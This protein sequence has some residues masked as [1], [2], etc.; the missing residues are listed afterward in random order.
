MN[1]IRELC[2]IEIIARSAKLLIKDGLTFLAD[3]EEAGFKTENIKKCVLHYLLEIFNYD[4]AAAGTSQVSSTQNIWDFVT[5]HARKKF[6]VTVER[7]ILGKIN[8]SSL[9]ISLCQKLNLRL[10]R[11]YRDIDFFSVNPAT[12]ER[13]FLTIEDIE[14]ITPVVKDYT[15]DQPVLNGGCK[16]EVYPTSL[17]LVL[18]SARA[19]DQAGKRSHWY[20]RGGEERDEATDLYRLAASVCEQIYGSTTLKYARILKEFAKHLESRHQEKGRPE[21]SRWNRSF[22]IVEDDLSSEARFFYNT[23]LQTLKDIG[24]EFTIDAAEIYVG[25]ARLVKPRSAQFANYREQ[26]SSGYDVY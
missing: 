13:N 7:D 20:M 10:R 1:H 26:D 14:G 18:E 2:V 22:A 23:S 15:E 3:D 25:L 6:Q 11:P 4:E 17:S 12:G 5:E 9:L 24:Q 19:K 8:M 21:N 16:E